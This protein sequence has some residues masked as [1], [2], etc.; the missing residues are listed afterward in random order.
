MFLPRD[1]ASPLD[2]LLLEQ[3]G[4]LTWRQATAE[5]TPSRVRHL[6]KTG[7]WRR[8]CRGVLAAGE[9]PLSQ[10]ALWWVA[11][12]AAGKGAVLA[13]LAGALAGGLRGRWHR[14]TID[15][16]VPYSRSAADLLRRLPI[17]LP[18]VRVRRTRHL[19]A[20]DRQWARP[21]RTTMA[22]SLVDAA[23]W[24]DSDREAQALLAAGCQQRKVTPEE[25]AATLER[26]PEI[27]RRALIR[28][29]VSDIAGGAQALSEID[30]VRLCRKHGLPLPD[31]QER[32]TD[33]QGRNRYLDAYWRRWRLHVEIDGAHHMDARQWADDMRRQNEVWLAGDRVLRFTA[34][35]V[36]NRPDYVIAQLR[37]AL[38]AAG[39]HPPS[40]LSKPA[41]L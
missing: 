26:M 25:I 1:D 20:S 30:F 17:D 21:T 14:Q 33:G 4:I 22:R 28:Q 5:L 8:I 40:E 18:A 41:E 10:E 29:T 34:F 32:R 16:L 39:W 24:A 3:S 2:W 37:A 27:G 36:R 31:Q 12:L 6:I 35:D 38:T 19:P 13:G 15:V 11:V 7:R 23:Q 9:G